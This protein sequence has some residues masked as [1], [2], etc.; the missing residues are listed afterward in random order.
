M[1]TDSV[2]KGGLFSYIATFAL[3]FGCIIGWGSFILPGT[4]IFIGFE[5]VSHVA[6]EAR[7]SLKHIFLISSIA[8]II[9]ALFINMI[10]MITKPEMN[11]LKMRQLLFMYINKQ[12]LKNNR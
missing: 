1:E 7:I 6:V 3:S 10:I 12:W 2:K 5:A 9:A 11:S 8:I 4:R